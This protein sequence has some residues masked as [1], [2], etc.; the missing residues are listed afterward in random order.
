MTARSELSPE[1]M[2]DLVDYDPVSGSFTWKPRRPHHFDEGGHSA[3]H[4]CARWNSRFAGKS[5]GTRDRYGYG[6]ITIYCVHY[7][8]AR[9]AWCILTGQWPTNE[10][11][12][13]NCDTGDD[14]AANL[15]EATTSENHGNIRLQSNNTSGFKG[16][17]WDKIRGKW[18]ANIKKNGRMF[19]LGR[20]DRKEDAAS[21]YEHAARSMFGEFARVA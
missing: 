9:V 5:A 13:I 4:I 15:R 11:D 20:F 14:R 16:V 3:A 12:H 6:I 10:I 8:C 19:N 2:R 17:S 18:Q 21:A 7:R 1:M